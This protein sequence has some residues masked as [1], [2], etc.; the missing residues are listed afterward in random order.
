MALLNLVSLVL[1]GVAVRCD[2]LALN[3]RRETEVKAGMR[4]PRSAP[5][6]RLTSP[7]YR[8]TPPIGWRLTD[9]DFGPDPKETLG[10]GVKPGAGRSHRQAGLIQ[11]GS[12]L[13]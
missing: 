6:S 10:K 12:A 3:L 7:D 13:S 5:S 11:L 8:P 1:R 2:R 9:A 4:T